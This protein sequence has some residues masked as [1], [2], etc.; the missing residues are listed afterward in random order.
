MTTELAT[1]LTRAITDA[2]IDDAADQSRTRI[3]DA[4]LDEAAAVGVDRLRVEDVV[5]RSGLGRMT[6]YR[7]FPKREDLVSAL[8]VRECQ[9]F[10][11]CVAVGLQGDAPPEERTAVAFV[12]AMRF[13][14]GHPLLRRVAET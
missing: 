11:L 12:E 4:A 8:V 6:V 9:R 5:R 1:L 3:L 14:R 10:L 2:P 13:V 7:R